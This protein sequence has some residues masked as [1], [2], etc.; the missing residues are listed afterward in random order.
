MWQ[1]SFERQIPQ[2]PNPRCKERLGWETT[3][4]SPQQDAFGQSQ[5]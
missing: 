1:A 4:R 5:T 2:K 3:L